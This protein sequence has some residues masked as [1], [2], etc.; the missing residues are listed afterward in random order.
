MSQAVI[1]KK[2]GESEENLFQVPQVT[3]KLKLA[4][5]G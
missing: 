1:K 4:L 3:E 5:L 2:E